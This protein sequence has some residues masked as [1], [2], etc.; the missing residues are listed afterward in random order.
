MVQI[1]YN[2]SQF[3]S[4]YAESTKETYLINVNLF[5]NY[6]K[7]N[8]INYKRIKKS[9]IYNYLAYMNNLARNT[10]KCRIDSIKN[11]YMFVNRDLSKYLFEGIKVYGSNRKTPNFLSSAQ[12]EGLLNY[13]KDKRNRL[14]IFLFLNTGIRISE[15]A[16]IRIE[17][18]HLSEKYIEIK[19][20]G[21][22]YRSVY[23][24]ELLRKLIKEYVA[25]KK[26]GLLFN[27]KRRQIHNIVTEPMKALGLKGSAH[28]LRHTFA[29]QIYMKTK[30]ILLVKELLGHRSI[31]S[32]Q[33]YTHLDNE[34]IKKTLEDN[35]LNL[36]NAHSTRD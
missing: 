15:L 8:K 32:T 12:I 31:A 5:L 10:K 18:I 6:C 7:Q 2:Y 36:S 33:I 34:I 20:K 28:T 13:Y 1:L 22:F 27:L 4:N 9:Q 30:D 26:S 17:N 25:D 16:N 29:T 24:N 35:P 23:I 11:F 3:L 19:V 14:I 21:G